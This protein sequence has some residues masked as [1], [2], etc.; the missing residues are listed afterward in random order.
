MTS[1][2]IEGSL[3]PCTELG[4]GERRTVA[5]TE[6]VQRLI[7]RGYFNVVA[8][9][10]I[11]TVGEVATLPGDDS[12]EIPSEPAE[13]SLKGVWQAWLDYKGVWY[14]TD[15]TKADLIAAWSQVKQQQADGNE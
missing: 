14:P 8:Y 4:R 7:D 5:L 1:V 3:T 2:T 11:E 13:D 15:A 12:A 9:H 10:E 6:R